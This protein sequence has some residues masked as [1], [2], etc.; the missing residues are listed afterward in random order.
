MPS[1][2]PP[3]SGT[4]KAGS[5]PSSGLVDR[6]PRYYEPLGLPPSTR[7]SC[8]APVLTDAVCEAIWLLKAFEIPLGRQVLTRRLGI[9]Y[10]A[11]RRLPRRDFPPHV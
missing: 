10:T 2:L 6:R 1:R 7:A 5:L 3:Y 9:C 4:T 8:I 11:L